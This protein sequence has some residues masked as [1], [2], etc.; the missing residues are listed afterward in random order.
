MSAKK[1]NVGND[2]RNFKD[3]KTGFLKP[4]DEEINN[5]L[6][7]VDDMNEY[8]K[9]QKK[10]KEILDETLEKQRKVLNLMRNNYKNKKIDLF[11]IVKELK[12]K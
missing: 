10:Q 1:Y 5:I 4:N 8:E 7:L 2:S 3:I 11:K 12:R 9:E 6:L